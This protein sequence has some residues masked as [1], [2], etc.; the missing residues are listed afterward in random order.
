AA[1]VRMRALKA[2]GVRMAIDDFGT[3]YSSLA[4]LRRF[5]IDV[6]KLDRSFISGIERNGPSAAM[7]EAFVRLGRALYIETVAEGVETS[8]E[9]ELLRE[10]DCQHAQG[11]LFSRPVD[12]ATIE[13]LLGAD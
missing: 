12:P 7:A 5:P 9:A 3:G 4:Y 13:A 1:D 11:F 10:L 2:L 6:L 8:T